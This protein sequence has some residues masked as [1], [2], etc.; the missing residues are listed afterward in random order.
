VIPAGGTVMNYVKDL[1][2]EGTEIKNDAKAVE[3]IN[4][5]LNGENKT[6]YYYII[7]NTIINN[8]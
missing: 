6:K 2:G 3:V 8:K 4:N 5:E 1:E 7:N